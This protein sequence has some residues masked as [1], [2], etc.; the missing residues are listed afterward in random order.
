MVV[1]VDKITP[2][3]AIEY[4]E[5]EAKTWKQIM[6]NDPEPEDA[7]AYFNIYTEIGNLIKN[8][9]A[10]IVELTEERISLHNDIARYNKVA[11]QTQICCGQIYGVC[12]VCG[13][14]REKKRE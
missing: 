7:Y 14:Q 5:S 12:P 1:C 2:E 4:L 13:K 9:H 11:E 10:Q 3:Q 6:D 8:Q